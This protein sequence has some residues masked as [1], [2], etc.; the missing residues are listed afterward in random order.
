MFMRL[1]K[2]RAIAAGRLTTLYNFCSQSGCADGAAPFGGLLLATD[3]NL[4]G[5]TTLGGS[6][7]CAADGSCGTIFKLSLVP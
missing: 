2:V 1:G 6:T 5:P 7:A 4:Y 3:G